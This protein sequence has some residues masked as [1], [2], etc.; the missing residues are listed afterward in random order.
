MT[1]EKALKSAVSHFVCWLRDELL[2]P[3]GGFISDDQFLSVAKE[4]VGALMPYIEKNNLS[5]IHEAKEVLSL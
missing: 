1:E 5:C 3:D 2:A 4:R